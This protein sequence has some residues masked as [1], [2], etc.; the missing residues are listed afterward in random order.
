MDEAHAKG[1]GAA[2]WAA[3]RLGRLLRP[4]AALLVATGG[5][6]ALLTAA[7]VDADAREQ[8]GWVLLFPLWFLAV[9]VGVVVAAPLLVAADERWGWRGPAALCGTTLALDVVRVTDPTTPLR[10]ASF[11]TVFVACHQVGLRWVA[12]ALDR[13]AGPGPRGGRRGRPRRRGRRPLP[14]RDGRGAR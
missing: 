14:P 11:A 13:F 9:Y 6:V 12:G 3:A 1:T 4:A 7:G 5:L 2:T 10:W 8:I